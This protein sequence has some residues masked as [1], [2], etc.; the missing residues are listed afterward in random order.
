MKKH[1][2]IIVNGKVQ[3]VFFRAS[4]KQMAELLGVKG[5]V[6]NESNGDVYVEAEGDEAMLVKFI[7]WCHHGP[8]SAEVKHVS[9]KDGVFLNYKNF[10]VIREN[11]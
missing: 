6:R 2:T 8:D 3:G 9:V 7:Q 11:K 1:Y 5:L 4:A 10:E